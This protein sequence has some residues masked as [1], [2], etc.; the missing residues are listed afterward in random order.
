MKTLDRA[1]PPAPATV[2]DFIF[3]EIARA[4]LGNELS[5]FAIPHGDLPVVT[6]QLV[7]H[8]GGE[9]DG[10]AAAGLS[11]LTARSLEAGTRS[12]SADRLAWDFEKLGAELDIDVLWD[13]AAL[14]VTAPADRAEASLALLAEVALDPAFASDEIERL[15]NEQLAEL[16]QRESEPRALA[17]DQA[18]R[19]IFSDDSTYHR[20]LPG[21]R[22]T[23]RNFSDEQVRSTYQR[24][25][26]A[27]NAALFGVG[28]VTPD[29]MLD[30]ANRHFSGWSGEQASASARVA[31]NAARAHVHLVHR[32]GSVQSEIRVGHV[33]VPR[34]HPDYYPLVIAN[35]IL[36]G[37]FTS[38][39][40]MNLREKHGFTYGVRSGFGFRKA[41]GPF[42]IQTAVATDVTARAAEEI[43]SETNGLLRDGPTDDELNAA[44]DYLSGTVPL[45]LQT[46]EQIADRAS[47]IFVFDLPED[48]F[49]E[50][51]AELRRVTAEQ[52]A[53]AARRHVRPDDFIWTIVGDAHALEKEIT[54]LNLGTIE[55]HELDD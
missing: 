36:G 41:P 49:E 43:L 40:N 6:F 3:P 11:Y 37:A 44:R 39:L 52:A 13:Y 15:K 4:S 26:R 8:A 28:A 12:R 31:P 32:E 34:I 55:V 25:W 14:T 17:S 47:E 23:V 16:L 38:R 1:H 18:I 45:E 48:H 20:P 54:A 2:R 7:V 10:P 33:G 30:L 46:T 9:H 51:R 19:F 27:G 50:Y 42:L 21:I 35:S 24:L 5:V 22:D 29:M 53:A